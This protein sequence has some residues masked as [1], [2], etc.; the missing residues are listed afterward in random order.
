MW[1]ITVKVTRVC[2]NFRFVRK[3]TWIILYGGEISG[4]FRQKGV[5]TNQSRA[6]ERNQ[7]LCPTYSPTLGLGKNYPGIIPFLNYG[8]CHPPP[9]PPPD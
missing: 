7:K 9:P 8:S 2:L 6:N 5:V 4:L 1:V 3:Y